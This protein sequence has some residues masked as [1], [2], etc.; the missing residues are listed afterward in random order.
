M[1]EKYRLNKVPTSGLWTKFKREEVMS[2]EGIRFF[3]ITYSVNPEEINEA[4]FDELAEK[5]SESLNSTLAVMLYSHY[6]AG[7]SKNRELG[8]NVVEVTIA[9]TIKYL[10]ELQEAT[11][12]PS[13]LDVKHLSYHSTHKFD[14]DKI[15]LK[16]LSDPMRLELVKLG[17]EQRF[18][19]L[20]YFNLE[21]LD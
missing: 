20:V 6:I 17:E 12:P 16:V 9:G 4:K 8:D 7:L 21:F 18:M 2:A 14:L 10:P 11:T 13:E 1:D 19:Y 3:G 15:V 5:F